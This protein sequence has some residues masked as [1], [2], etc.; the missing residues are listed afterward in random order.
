[1]LRELTALIGRRD[2]KLRSLLD[3]ALLSP[4]VYSEILAGKLSTSE[5]KFSPTVQL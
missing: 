5:K 3:G 1:V 2:G 4:I